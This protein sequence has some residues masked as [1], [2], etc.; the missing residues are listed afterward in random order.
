MARVAQN[1]TISRWGHVW[2][3]SVGTAFTSW[4]EPALT[5]VSSR[6]VWPVAPT[7]GGGA[8][9]RVASAAAGF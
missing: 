8:A 5:T 9:G 2:T 7:L 6:W 4:M 1:S 3:L